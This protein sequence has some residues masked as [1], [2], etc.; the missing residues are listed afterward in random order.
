MKRP[1]KWIKKTETKKSGHTSLLI[2]LLIDRWKYQNY[3][4]FTFFTGHQRYDGLRLSLFESHLTQ[5]TFPPVYSRNRDRKR[6]P[7]SVLVVRVNPFRSLRGPGL[8]RLVSRQTGVRRGVVPSTTIVLRTRRQHTLYVSRVC[9]W[10]NMSGVK[11]GNL[12]YNQ[13]RQ[14][15]VD[16]NV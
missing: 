12:S 10:D 9:G 8:T 16:P 14:P 2:L 3:F 11:G 7:G 1:I 15:R 5:R 13:L 6:S 4:Y